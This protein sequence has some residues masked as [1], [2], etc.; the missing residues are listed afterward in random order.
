VRRDQL[1]GFA[2]DLCLV[3][4]EARNVRHPIKDG[5]LEGA[6]YERLRN[7]PTNRERAWEAMQDLRVQASLA[8]SALAASRMFEQRFKIGLEPLLDLYKSECW[9]SSSYGGNP[10]VVITEAV[11]ELRDALARSD[12]EQVDDLLERI[13]LMHHHTGQVGDKLARLDALLRD[14]SA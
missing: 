6:S 11:M 9:G 4:H 7:L 12:S 1:D 14:G 13:Q 3:Y 5:C 8:E 2:S 10:W